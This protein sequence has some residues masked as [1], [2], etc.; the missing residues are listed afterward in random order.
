MYTTKQPIHFLWHLQTQIKKKKIQ[1][2]K[3]VKLDIP[4]KM[5]PK[6]LTKIKLPFPQYLFLTIFNP[7]K[8]SCEQ[9]HDFKL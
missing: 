6:S 4:K 3:I 8:V 1:N 7:K 2:F 9:T 5:T